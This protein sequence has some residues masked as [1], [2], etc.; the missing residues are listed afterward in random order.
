MKTK[1]LLKKMFKLLK[2]IDENTEKPVSSGETE[3][4][5]TLQQ[6]ML[7]AAGPHLV[8]KKLTDPKPEGAT[9]KFRRP[10]AFNT[11]PA[12]EGQVYQPDCLTKGQGRLVDEVAPIS[13]LK[14]VDENDDV[15]PA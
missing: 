3:L 8:L 7:N 5:R 14:P 10:F 6:A 15:R 12:V 4:Q 13:G 11:T 9:I 2:K 1:K